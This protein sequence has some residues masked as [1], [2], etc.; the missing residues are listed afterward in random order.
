MSGDSTDENNFGGLPVTA[1]PSLRSLSP[2]F[3]AEQHEIYVKILEEQLGKTGAEVPLNLALTGHYGSGKS[4]VLVEVYKRLSAAERVVVNLSLPS[5]G[6]GDGRVPQEGGREFDK[7]NLIQK[8]IVKQLLYRRKP[9]STPASRY[10]R[11]DTFHFWPAFWRSI[12]AGVVGAV[13]ALVWKLPSR[14]QESVPDA[15][16][17]WLDMHFL[18][19]LSATL[20]W[21]SLTAVFFAVAGF[22]VWVQR[23][24]QQRI[25]VTELAAGPTKIT[26]SES[27]SSYFDEYLDE[28][29]YFF[30]TSKTTVVIFEDLDRFKDPH[31]FEALR[32]LNLLLNNAE[33]TGQ[34]PISFVYA[35]RDSIFEQL[36]D[37]V[38]EADDVPGAIST[39]DKVE[40]RRLMSTNRTKFFDLVVPMVPFI[41]HRTSRGLITSELSSIEVHQKP[42]AAIVDLVSVH[43]TDMRLIKNLCNEYEIFLDKIFRRDGLQQL[44]P[45]LLFASVVYKNVYLVDYEKIRNGSSELDTVYIAYRSWVSQQTSAARA[46]ERDA[47]LRLRRLNAVASR[48]VALGRRLQQVL[49]AY[50]PFDIVSRPVQ[51][52]AGGVA[53][54][55]ANLT[56]TEFWQ[57]YIE[58][59]QDLILALGYNSATLTFDHAQTLIGRDLSIADWAAADRAELETAIRSAALDQRTIPHSSI[60]EVIDQTD[61][62]FTLEDREAINF[63]VFICEV[64]KDAPLVIEMLRAGFIDENF[65]LYTTQFPGK[66]MSASAMN[67]ILKAVQPDVRDVEYHFGA[68]EDSDPAD[69]QAVIAAEGSR[70]LNGQSV[71][72]IEIFDHLLF[73]DSSQLSDAIRRLAASAGDDLSFIDAYLVT[74]KHRFTFIKLLSGHWPG[75]FDYLLKNEAEAADLELLNAAVAG[76]R[77][78]VDYE[79]SSDQRSVIESSLRDLGV[80]TTSQPAD[81]TTRIAETFQT[82]KIQSSDLST[83]A[84]SLRQKLVA[85]GLYPVTLE[86]LQTIFADQDISLDSIKRNREMDVYP[87]VLANL[88]SYIAA[89]DASG[90]NPSV[91][92]SENFASVLTDV[93]ENSDALVEE[94]ARRSESG[95]MIESIDGVNVSLWPQ[96]AAAQKVTLSVSNVI[97]YTAE[98]GIDTELAN[99]LQVE[100]VLTVDDESQ[101]ILPLAVSILNSERLDRDVKL[102]LSQCLNLEAGSIEVS[103]LSEDGRPMISKL[104]ATNLVKDD[105]DAYLIL[106]EDDWA[107]KQELISASR[108][109]PNYLASIPLSTDDLY[110]IATQ[111]VSYAAKNALLTSLVAFDGSLGSRGAVALAEWA[112]AEGMSVST[113]VLA[114]LARR[115]SNSSARSVVKLLSAQVS[116]VELSELRGIL[117]SLGSPYAQLTMPGR[118]RPRVPFSDGVERILA[119]LQDEGIVTR[120]PANSRKHVFEV[121]KRHSST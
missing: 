58:G 29:V 70:L 50:T 21:L 100:R 24:L 89:L 7:T 61:R 109:F 47:K 105:P 104:V 2:K 83:V 102:A 11:L 32:E 25:R 103:E 60:S 15:F 59:R 37:I 43:L 20:Q 19:H 74:G 82:L 85:K 120:W 65:T 81:R 62:L 116:E 119:R 26:L 23:L 75:L 108:E 18:P 6:V 67:F 10:N 101:E 117:N 96:I 38:G 33:Q 97:A 84:S 39:G 93:A 41:S 73:S 46:S 69:V 45:D 57:S 72:N 3:D 79:L 35:I 99:F 91:R 77:P 14:I 111:P 110:R 40:T 68:G 80:M 88:E 64:F 63:E 30:Q 48:S 114:V 121:S 78:E 16:W 113:E 56:S 92:T 8:E 87:H 118:E 44:N 12:A 54:E 36:D 94:I 1:V 13:L 71:Y 27:T 98:Y 49:I 53:V 9:S 115:G 34:T 17:A 4:S 5:L 90:S 42:S 55:W 66:S 112:A 106:G 95:V 107:I 51:I 86:N 31:I 76:V 52:S 22:G 28:I